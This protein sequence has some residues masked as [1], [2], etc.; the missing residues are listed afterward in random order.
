LTPYHGTEA[1]DG[2]ATRQAKEKDYEQ[3]RRDQSRLHLQ[4]RRLPLQSVHL[5]QLQ[6]L[7]GAGR[8]G[9]GAARFGDLAQGRSLHVVRTCDVSATVQLLSNR[10]LDADG[11]RHYPASAVQLFWTVFHLTYYPL[12][13][14]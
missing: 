9:D 2:F 8:A 1:K 11:S 7:I 14:S 5:P 13:E 10:A 12:G 4:I 6:L 3:D